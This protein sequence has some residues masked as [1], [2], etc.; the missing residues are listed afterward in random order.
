VLLEGLVDTEVVDAIASRIIDA[1]S[2]P[3][4]L[5]GLCV[6]LSISIGVAVYPAHALAATEL[7]QR[8]DLAMYRAK[9]A[10]GRR[11]LVWSR[12]RDDQS[13]SYAKLESNQRSASVTDNPLRRA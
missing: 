10:G 1:L 11:Y 5:D 12:E 9:H 7:L 6:R 4:S 13:G 2:A 3:F 8:A